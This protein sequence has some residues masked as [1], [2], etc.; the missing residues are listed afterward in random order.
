MNMNRQWR[1]IPDFY[2]TGRENMFLDEALALRVSEGHSPPTL[3]IYP[4]PCPAVSLGRNQ[5]AASLLNT[6]ACRSRGIEIVRRPTGGKAIQHNPGDVTYSVITDGGAA[7]VSHDVLGSY[8]RITRA[9]AAGL[10]ILGVRAAMRPHAPVWPETG[11]DFG[12]FESPGRHEVYW[13]GRKII[14]SAQR[15]TAGVILQQ[16][17]IPIS[18]TG[19]D[20]AAL[21]HLDPGRRERLRRDLAD[22][23]GTLARV[24]DAVPA[25]ERVMDALTEGFRHS[26]GLDLQESP[27]TSVE[28]GLLR[29]LEA[30]PRRGAGLS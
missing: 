21:L 28:E 26:W 23:T 19:A 4:W 2:R 3:R 27:I 11:V 15:R 7:T 25:F 9:L 12:C 14:A 16:G 29:R 8:A 18:E 5:R 24:L 13:A 30:E 17:T 20:L 6:D 1:L 22:R 10:S